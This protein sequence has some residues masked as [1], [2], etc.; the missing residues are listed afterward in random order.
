VTASGA[1]AEL[2]D[3]LGAEIAIRDSV[4]GLQGAA[5]VP[6]VIEPLFELVAADVPERKRLAWRIGEALRTARAWRTETE[7]SHRS[8]AE[9]IERRILARRVS[10]LSWIGT[11][12]EKEGVLV[13]RFLE[14]MHESFFERLASV[15]SPSSSAL[16]AFA[17]LPSIPRSI[18]DHAKRAL[19]DDDDERRAA[20]AIVLQRATDL[21]DE[22][23]ARI[24][25][26][27]GPS[28]TERWGLLCRLFDCR[29]LPLPMTRFRGTLQTAEV[30]FVGERTMTVRRA[31]GANSTIRAVTPGAKPGACVEIGVSAHGIVRVVVHGATRIDFDLCGEP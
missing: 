7:P 31:D 8:L 27:L 19:S 2:D 1:A 22:T 15:S 18:F 17:G 5:L 13:A 6:L 28:P 26:V 3:Q 20:A 11:D 23:A 16:F 25:E 24:D 12:L 29:I 10:L 30:L 21:D 4:V 9:E 14:P